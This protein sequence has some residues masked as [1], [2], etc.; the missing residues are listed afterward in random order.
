MTSVTSAPA[1]ASTSTRRTVRSNHW[2]VVGLSSRPVINRW[3]P[4]RRPVAPPARNSDVPPSTGG[5]GTA[6]RMATALRSGR[7]TSSTVVSKVCGV[8]PGPGRLATFVPTG[9]GTSTGEPG[10]SSSVN[11][12]T[13]SEARPGP[14]S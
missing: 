5:A 8:S 3:S 1:T 12:R 14:R 2:S 9:I 13:V 11:A 4:A 10:L 6:V 7:A